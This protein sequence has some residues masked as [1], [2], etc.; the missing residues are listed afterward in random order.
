MVQEDSLLQRLSPV[1]L[2]FLGFLSFFGSFWKPL[3]YFDWFFLF[4]F[5]PYFQMFRKDFA[6]VGYSRKR[7]LKI[8]LKEFAVIFNPY[9]LFQML[10]QLCGELICLIRT[11]LFR[12]NL[13]KVS[14]EVQFS[15]P[16]EGDWVAMSGGT[17]KETSHSWEILNQRYAYD[18][19]KMDSAK[20]SFQNEGKRLEDYYAFGQ[21]VCAP[22]EGTVVRICDGLRDYPKLRDIDLFARGLG[23]N[24]VMIQHRKRIV[25]FIAHLQQGS[26]CIRKGERVQK[27][28]I[29]GRCGNSGNSTEP[30]IHFQI[31]DSALPFFGFGLPVFFEKKP[32]S[33]KF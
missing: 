23:G 14:K 25:S 2:G 26:V 30:H 19:V 18:F 12:P 1:F 16:F 4:F 11:I 21:K 9:L 13:W 7:L 15:F 5:I 32:K 17:D 10:W 20:K 31:Q 29:I 22:A 6:S 8:F 28:Q 27:G 33:A 3:N 24:Y